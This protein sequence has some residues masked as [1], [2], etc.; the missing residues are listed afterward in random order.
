M[1]VYSYLQIALGCAAGGVTR[2]MITNFSQAMGWT[3]IGT[4]LVNVIGCLLAGIVIAL[5]IHYL[6]A[7]TPFIK[8]FLLIGFLGGLTTFSAFAVDVLHLIRDYQILPAALHIL[9]NVSLSL[10]AVFAGFVLVQ[11]FAGEVI[12]I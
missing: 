4:L 12:K 9:L 5:T 6:Q 10:L 7:H 8:A 11:S 2:A 1:T 3:I